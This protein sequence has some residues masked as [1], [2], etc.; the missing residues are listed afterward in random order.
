MKQIFSDFIRQSIRS[1]KAF[2]SEVEIEVEPNSRTSFVQFL[3]ASVISLAA[4]PALSGVVSLGEFQIAPELKN[5]YATPLVQTEEELFYAYIRKEGPTNQTVLVQFA[6]QSYSLQEK[7]RTILDNH[8]IKDTWHTAPSIGTAEGPIIHATYGMHNMPWQYS[9]YDSSNQTLE[10]NGESITQEQ[11]E[12]VEK[13]NKT[14]FKSMGT[15][16]IPGQQI[17]YPALFHLSEN[18]LAITYRYATRPARPFKD[19]GYAGGLSIFHED[20][21]SW[22]MIGDSAHRVR[23]GDF[24][25][26]IETNQNPAPPFL[27][28]EEAVP[29]LLRI[30]EDRSGRVHLTWT[31]RMGH[32][33]PDT[34]LPSYS[35][36]DDLE[37][38]YNLDGNELQLPIDRLTQETALVNEGVYSPLT[39]IGQAPDG[40]LY[41]IFQEYQGKFLMMD[42]NSRTISQ[43]PHGISQLITTRRNLY[44]IATGPII[45][46]L[47]IFGRFTEY[48]KPKSAN[49]HCYH[50]AMAGLPVKEPFIIESLACDASSTELFFVK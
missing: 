41:L 22:K 42:L 21:S 33:G 14:P 31:W 5:V 6:L 24:F 46:K 13:R 15:A 32:A 43:S 48:A 50:R 3:L 27:F 28:D 20:T 36:T 26:A 30:F 23:S 7:S 29:Y 16:A 12:L 11:K 37:T 2:A 4:Q 18:I 19:R 17:T 35:Y 47:G 38:F 1:D 10:F 34:I 9:Q 40:T 25:P 39:T 8:T 44:G 49:K 45:Y